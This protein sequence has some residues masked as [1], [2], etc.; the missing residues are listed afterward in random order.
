MPEPL[1]IFAGE[2]YRR[3]DE[4]AGG[5]EALDVRKNPR[6][7]HVGYYLLS[8]SVELALKAFLAAKGVT[9]R[10][11]RVANHDHAALAT[12]AGDLGLTAVPSLDDLLHGLGIMNSEQALRYPAGRFE[13]TPD[14][15]E[16]LAVLRSLL[17]AVLPTVTA[18]SIK[19]RVR[20]AGEARGGK[21]VEWS[22]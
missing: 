16:C 20:L 12:R 2:L 1:G 7:L 15:D 4:F 18:E 6:F 13:G 11:I 22:D 17:A 14:P 10:E 19:A 8:H 5:F 3:A 21:R 9:K